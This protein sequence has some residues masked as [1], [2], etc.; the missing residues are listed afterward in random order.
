MDEGGELCGEPLLR[1]TQERLLGDRGLEL[2]DLLAR[3]EGEPLEVLDDV[4]VGRVHEVLV[5][6]VRRGEL[7]VEPQAAAAGGLTELG[8]V[9]RGDQRDRHCMRAAGFHLA[10]QVDAAE[11]VAPLIGAAD[12]EYA[13]V[14][15]VQLEVVVGL[16]QQVA[17]LG[18]ADAIR[19]QTTLDRLARQHHVDRE[20]LAD[21][22][23]EVDGG[24]LADP[25]EVV[26][27]HRGGG[28]LVDRDETLQ[29]PDDL[30]GPAG[31][32]VGGIHGALADVAGIA[33]EAGRSAGE[34][35][36]TMAGHLEATQ[37]QQRHQVTG[38]QAGGGG[39]EARVQRDRPFGEDGTQCVGVGR[40]ADQA[41]PGQLVEEVG[42]H[43]GAHLSPASP[44]SS[45]CSSS[46]TLRASAISMFGMPRS[47]IA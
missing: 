38:V 40:L 7:G 34:H 5:P 1:G 45:R 39:V 12:L 17:E 14:P 2:G 3:Q 43:G 25:V 26:D 20:V 46:P 22:P 32:G 23:Q 10:D 19:F 4:G 9:G 30:V 15:A 28:G 16:Q 24:E 47:S 36:G 13:P 29:L 41:A 33:D 8:A 6:D 37:G 44:V 27:Q 11:D 21:V 31:H 42:I 18:V 35:D